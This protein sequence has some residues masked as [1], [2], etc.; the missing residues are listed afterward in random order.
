MRGMRWSAQDGVEEEGKPACLVSKVAR[1]G[2]IEWR[3][4]SVLFFCLFATVSP[5]F[6]QDHGLVLWHMV[7]LCCPCFVSLSPST[8]S[9]SPIQSKYGP[10][11]G[12]QPRSGLSFLS[13]HLHICCLGSMPTRWCVCKCFQLTSTSYHGRDHDHASAQ[14]LCKIAGCARYMAMTGNYAVMYLF[15]FFFF[16]CLAQ[17]GRRDQPVSNPLSGHSDTHRA[18]RLSR[19]D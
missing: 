13:F 14:G 18:C 11:A 10:G 3:G 6:I 5:A 15:F 2:N 12:A 19:Q 8:A 16:F 4:S 7:C 17:S 9:V 1:K